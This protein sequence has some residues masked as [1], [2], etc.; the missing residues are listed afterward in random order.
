MPVFADQLGRNIPIESSP[1]RIISAVPSQ[2]EL[3]FDLGLD[4]EVVGITRFCIHPEKWFR[5][6]QKVGGTK[7]LDLDIIH[8]LNPDLIIGNKEENSKEDIF[9]LEKYFPVWIS[10]VKTLADSLAMINAI[11]EICHK[12]ISAQA[13][14]SLIKEKFAGIKQ[15]TR[16]IRAAYFIWRKP[17]MAAGRDS[18]INEMM[19]YCSF[20][21]IFNTGDRYPIT[22]PEELL[23]KKCELLLLASEPFPFKE[24]NVDELQIVLPDVK[25]KLVDGEMFSWYG[26]RLIH[27]PLYFSRLLSE[28]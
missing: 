4:T 1:K 28:I 22:N 2:T 5:K 25:I 18:F 20:E 3:L 7:K 6:K 12:Q 19:N 14:V 23:E 11:G 24:K 26:S 10:D 21:N 16:K 13:M 17:Y 9:E 15:E 27:S 8:Q